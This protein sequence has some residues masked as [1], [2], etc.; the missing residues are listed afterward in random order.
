MPH[1]RSLQRL[2]LVAA[3]WLVTTAP[4]SFAGTWYV[5]PGGSGSGTSWADS[6]GVVQAAIDSATAGDE[7]WVASGTYNESIKMRTGVALYGG[8]NGT[9]TLQEQGDWKGNKTTIDAIGL[10][11]R[12]VTAVDAMS[13]TINGF[14][15]KNGMAIGYHPQDYGGG[16][17][18]YRVASATVKNCTIVDNTAS[19]RGGGMACSL[20][21]TTVANCVIS[22]N[23]T[24]GIGG[25]LCVLGNYSFNLTS[26]K[27]ARNKSNDYGGGVYCA[28]FLTMTNCTF[29]DNWA[30]YGGGLEFS[31]SSPTLTNCT[32]TN[33]RAGFSGGGVHCIFSLPTFTNCAISN[34]KTSYGSG[35]AML[36]FSSSPSLSNCTIT[37]NNSHNYGGGGYYD[38]SS[39]SLTNCTIADNQASR[40]QA[41]AFDSDSYFQGSPSKVIA[42]NTII[43]NATDWLWNNDNSTLVLTYSDI[44]GGWPQGDGNIEAAPMFVD[45]VSG[46]YRLQAG[47]PCIDSGSNNAVI[48][49]GPAILAQG[50]LDHHVRIWDG[51]GDW[52]PNVDMGAFE[53]GPPPLAGD[54]NE[55]AMVDA[56]DLFVFQNIWHATTSPPPN[57]D[58]NGDN[59]F[60]ADDL[61]ILEH[62]RGN[63]TYFAPLP[64]VR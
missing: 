13:V 43:W 2:S 30:Y 61:I 32:I 20:S 7:I 10:N 34:N 3:V 39:L 24:S 28:S 19:G 27:V 47:S 17:Y 60:D 21:R 53:Y 14:T 46:D 48:Q 58:Q 50:D 6:I 16:I 49:L 63:E 11:K 23:S 36:C 35:G 22:T 44:E 51:N 25:G 4:S 38:S 1:H 8:F 26:C 52:T 15:I 18:L 54:L 64:S 59:L 42:A 12:V 62:S 56:L 31:S 57:P 5:T 9:E 37:G 40:A 45:A 55:D 29:T 41:L 33:N